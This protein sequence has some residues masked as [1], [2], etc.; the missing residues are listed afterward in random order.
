MNKFSEIDINPNIKFMTN[1][2][3]NNCNKYGHKFYNCKLPI[4]SYGIILFRYNT[5]N[6]LEYLMIRRKNSYG[7]V[8]IIQGKYS[9]ND[10][11]Q[12]QKS[13]NEMSMFEKELILSE[14]FTNLWKYMWNTHDIGINN[15]E[16]KIMKMEDKKAQLPLNEKQTSLRLLKQYKN[17]ELTCSKKFD[18]LK[19]QGIKLYCNSIFNNSSYYNNMDYFNF[20]R[21][22]EEG[23]YEGE[24]EE[25]LRKNN[26]Y[27]FIKSISLKELI[28]TSN[29]KWMETEWEFPKGRKNLMEKDIDCA[30]REFEEETG[31]PKNDINIINNILPFEELYV[32]S[33]DKVYK[34]KFFLAIMNK[35]T[36]KYEYT[37]FQKTEVSKIEWKTFENCINSLRD[38]NI[39]KKN[40]L[41]NVDNLLKEYNIIYSSYQPYKS[42]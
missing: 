24:K 9:L 39:E 23:E 14:N 19:K 33:N 20:N 29:T 7:F 34:T 8:E 16:N 41:Y 13:I 28:N 11:I 21:E 31:I 22:Y 3:C 35:D 42:T 38:Y 40:I 4:I 27:Q 25:L 32:G 12:I 17:E 18:L 36:D 26:S 30:L 5:S 1:N 6:K 37:N 2:I 10:I 15:N